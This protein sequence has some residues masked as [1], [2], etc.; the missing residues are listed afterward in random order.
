MGFGWT[1]TLLIFGVILLIFG[2]SKLPELARNLGSS[3]NVFKEEVTKAKDSIEEE[4]PSQP[5]EEQAAGV[6]RS[7]SETRQQEEAATEPSE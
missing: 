7:R 3:I 6:N 1:E 2:P 4:V 5:L